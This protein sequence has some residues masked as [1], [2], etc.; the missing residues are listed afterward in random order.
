[1]SLRDGPFQDL[2]VPLA[3][4][5]GAALIVALIA[6]VAFLATNPKGDP[7]TK[8]Y[9][10]ARQLFDKI[11]RPVSGVLSKPG[12]WIS[13]GVHFVGDYFF[14]VSENRRLKAELREMR[15][16]EDRAVALT[17]ENR[18]L[19]AILGLRTDPPIPMVAGR[20]VLDTR[21]PY[22]NTRL[23]NVGREAGV[24]IG[25]PVMND[26]GLVGRIVGVS[27]GVS[28]VLLLSDVTS[29]MPVLNARTDARAIL[30]GDAGPNP[31]LAYMRG[32]DPV[33]AGDRILTSGDGGVIP[34]GLPVGVA[35]PGLDRQWRV[36]L[37][38]D[39][40]SVDYVQ[41]LKFKDFA[42]LADLAELEKTKMPPPTAGDAAA[43]QAVHTTANAPAPATSGGSTPTRSAAATPAPAR[44]AAAKP[45]APKPA[46]TGSK[47]RPGVKKKG[48]I[49]YNTYIRR[50]RSQQQGP[51]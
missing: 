1:V 26:R 17:N 9:G 22:A 15:K 19:K 5:A 38:A 2:K 50:K 34:R 25:N 51:G 32:A 27:D 16:S 28:R 12:E 47:P 35:A 4:T 3:W 7:Q 24:Q 49:P 39:L 42:Q 45:G 33:K 18:R 13:D 20:T 48:P 11:D 36:R 21:G 43:A 6:A 41:V 30:T 14:A 8:A 29:R 31:R 44:P 46:A 40:E 37:A 10:A 23:I